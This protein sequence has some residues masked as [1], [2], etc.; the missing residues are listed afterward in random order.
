M[1]V[2]HFKDGSTYRMTDN[3]WRNVPNKQNITAVDIVREADGKVFT[4]EKPPNTRVQFFSQRIGYA[5]M[6][7]SK[8]LITTLPVVEE[9]V[10]MIFDE[11]HVE[12]L[13]VGENVKHYTASFKSMGFN[14]LSLEL[15]GIT[16]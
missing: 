11:N 14:Q 12:L 16:K 10:G 9:Q 4:L 15:L 2:V 8:R 7:P 3:L 13:E 6:M 1:I 5:H